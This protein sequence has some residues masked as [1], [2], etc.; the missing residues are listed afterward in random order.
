MRTKTVK[1]QAKKLMPVMTKKEQRTERQA[2]ILIF[3]FIAIIA[4]FFTV[5]YVQKSL[6]K[7]YFDFHGFKVYAVQLTGSNMIFYNIPDV[8]FTVQGLEYKKNVVIR[9]DPRVLEKSNI[10]INVDN[11]FFKT[12]PLQLWMSWSS[13]EKAKIYEAEIEIKKFANNLNI[14]VG[15]V[16]LNLSWNCENSSDERRTIFLKTTNSTKIY[17]N[18]SYPYCLTIEADSYDN[19]IK[20][21]DSFV[22][23]WLLRIS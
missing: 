13:E 15:V 19:L 14:P 11:I 6:K 2:L 5:Y 8:T 4:A 20:A 21:C 3:V 17:K 22:I 23:E 7:P 18:E 12:M 1:K 9:T 16:P 10:S